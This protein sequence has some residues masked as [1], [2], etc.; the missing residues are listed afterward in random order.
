MKHFHSFAAC[1]LV[2]FA[3]ATPTL[4]GTITNVA[5]GTSF[6]NMFNGYDSINGLRQMTSNGTFQTGTATSSVTPTNASVTFN[7]SVFVPQTGTSGFGAGS[8]Y[9]NLATGT[10]GASASSST[11]VNNQPGAVPDRTQ[12]ML[13][14]SLTFSN[15]T[16]H[17]VLIDVYWT[18]DGI[19]STVNSI[20]NGINFSSYFCFESAL[21]CQVQGGSTAAGF[22]IPQ[23]SS[24]AAFNYQYAPVGFGGFSVTTPSQGWVSSSY[25]STPLSTTGQLLPTGTNNIAVTFHGVYSV[26]AGMSTDSVYANILLSCGGGEIVSQGC[27]FSHTGA[28]SFSLNDPGVSF[29]SG[30]GVLLTAS[31]TPEPGT[32]VLILGGLALIVLGNLRS[33]LV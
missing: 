23:G 28:L 26:P 18:F 20:F 6:Y 27:D 25:T 19:T 1:A 10:I 5:V 24:P 4:A 14:D 16:G 15:V 13:Q 9:A 2:T 21:G 7:G 32:W 12:A 11:S 31:A 17:S 29:T 3:G 33:R 22:S 8:A 30:S